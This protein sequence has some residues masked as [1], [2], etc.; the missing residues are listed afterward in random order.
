MALLRAATRHDPTDRQSVL[1]LID[2]FS[3]RL[4][5]AVHEVPAG[6]LYGFDGAS[7]EQCEE[8]E[9]EL[10]EFCRL[11]DEEGL[12]YRYSELIRKCRRHFRAYRNYL[13]DHERYDSYADYLSQHAV[14]SEN[15]GSSAP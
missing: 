1:R 10:D 5:Y 7:P 11:V 9:R 15:A 2:K 13:L 8:L 14:T 12:E 3:D 6:V 4:R